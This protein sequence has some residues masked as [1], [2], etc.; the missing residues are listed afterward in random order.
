MGLLDL[1]P[2][3]FL[4]FSHPISLSFHFLG[5]SLLELELFAWVVTLV[6]HLDL[7]L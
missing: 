5:W 6:A 7:S 2:S 3:C 4:L 1:L